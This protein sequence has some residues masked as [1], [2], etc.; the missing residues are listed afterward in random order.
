[1]FGLSTQLTTLLILCLA[2]AC[3][4][5]LINGFHDTANAV[6][7]VIY[8]NALKPGYAV[9]WSAI[10]NFI[11]VNVGGIAVAIGII[12]IL[13]VEALVDKSIYHGLSMIASLILTAIIWNLGTW[14]FGIPCSSSHT[15][16]GSIFGVG[17]AYMML[18]GSSSVSLNWHKVYDIG[19]SLLISPFIGF[20]SALLLMFLLKR[21]VKNKILYKEPPA[22]KAPPFWIRTILILTCTS[23]SFTHGSNDGQKGVGLVMMILIAFVPTYFAIDMQKNPAQLN[24]HIAII[25]PIIK[26][27]TSSDTY[28]LNEINTISHRLDTIKAVMIGR[29]TFDDE[30]STDNFEIRKDIL[31]VAKAT[32]KI[33]DDPVKY[34]VQGLTAEEIKRLGNEV[35][36]VRPFTEYA[37][38]WVILMISISLG[39]GT[40]V[41]W[42]RIVITIGEK[43]GKTH[44]SYAQGAVANLIAASTIGLSSLFGL[45]VSTT[46]VLSSGVAGSMVSGGGL[47]NLQG[48]TITNIIVAWLIT[49]PV[50][51]LLSGMLFLLFNLFLA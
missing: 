3:I 48:K 34:P 19:L 7:S 26:K 18:P 30:K 11:G 42:K 27:A 44:L 33:I 51:I 22:K 47:K 28:T 43:I 50:T 23:V 6:A 37:P 41:G 4:F 17:L 31:L 12:N 32:K 15:L 46:H 39:I 38:W 8:T 21:T 35:I 10:C 2:A 29:T 13:P 9:V 49:L 16:I 40:M 14:Y 25:D 45:P 20:F 1:M 5:E 36:Q 24:Q